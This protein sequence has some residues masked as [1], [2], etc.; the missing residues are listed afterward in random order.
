MRGCRSAFFGFQGSLM[1][2]ALS[3]LGIDEIR[4]IVQTAVVHDI[5]MTRPKA[6]TA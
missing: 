5:L 1:Q 4:A 2:Q 6:A 3:F